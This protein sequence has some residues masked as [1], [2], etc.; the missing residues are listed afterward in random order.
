MDV[1]VCVCAFERVVLHGLLAFQIRQ[2]DVLLANL[3][4]ASDATSTCIVPTLADESHIVE[5]PQ[6]LII[7]NDGKHDNEQHHSI[8]DYASH[9]PEYIH[10]CATW[11]RTY[12]VG[13]PYITLV[14]DNPSTIVVVVH[15]GEKGTCRIIIRS[16][17]KKASAREMIYDGSKR[18]IDICILVCWLSSSRAQS[19]SGIPS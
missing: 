3:I 15:H 16:T 18:L 8:P 6:Y 19:T 1:C 2:L 11:F 17:C 13:K 14:G 12:F 10:P 7:D 4:K 5:T 9:H